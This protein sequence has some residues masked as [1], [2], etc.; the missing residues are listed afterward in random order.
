MKQ[1][2]YSFLLVKKLTTIITVVQSCLMK[3]NLK[4]VIYYYYPPSDCPNRSITNSII[5][6]AS[7]NL[8]TQRN[9]GDV[10]PHLPAGIAPALGHAK[11]L[12]EWHGIMVS[13]KS[14]HYGRF[15][16]KTKEQ[17]LILMI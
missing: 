8:M 2:K 10:L 6:T 14:F 16:R 7:M 15:Q 3:M 5:T 11:P 1:E 9:F 12:A 13:I 17:G 4:I